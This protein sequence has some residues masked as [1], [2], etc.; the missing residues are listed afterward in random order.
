VFNGMERGAQQAAFI[1]RGIDSIVAADQAVFA[2][3][4]KQVGEGV[5]SESYLQ[6]SGNSIYMKQ[7]RPPFN[8]IRVRRATHLAIDRQ[9]LLK[10]VTFGAGAI[11]PPGGLALHAFSLPLEE[12]VKL[13]GWRQPKDQDLAE[14]K[15]L[16]AEAGYPNGL[17]VTIKTSKD[18]A[19][20]VPTLEALS[21]MLKAVGIDAQIAMLERAVWI[22]VERDGDYEAWI[23]TLNS[24]PPTQGLFGYY[25]SKGALNKAPINDPEM[26]T[27]IEDLE[28]TLDRK[29][30]DELNRRIQRLILDKVYTISTVEPASFVLW[31][32]WLHNYNH[33][34]GAQ[35]YVV[36]WDALWFETD[37]APPRT[38]Q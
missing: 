7:D 26:D 5:K 35:G 33:N 15:R 8:D 2:G 17:K 1:A 20:A 29:K 23:A 34:Y 30:S 31:Q 3:L 19:G 14:A 28:T 4:K 37:K 32:P 24:D 13:P 10:T 36:Q 18:L 22:Q 16:L 21:P 12:L 9:G 38:L 25:H 11:N 6:T 27:L